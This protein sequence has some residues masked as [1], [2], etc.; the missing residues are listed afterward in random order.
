MKHPLLYGPALVFGLCGGILLACQ[1]PVF[2][3]ALERWTAGTWNIVVLSQGP[4]SPAQSLSLQML[5]QPTASASLPMKIQHIDLSVAAPAD[6]RRWASHWQA[7][8]NEAIPVVVALYPQP[9]NV[10]QPVASLMQ[11]S[12]TTAEQILSSPVR[13]ELASRLTAGHSAVWLFLDSGETQADQNALERLN[14]QLKADEQRLTLPTAADLQITP[15]QLR[16]LQIPLKLQF[17]VLRLGR[18][19][20][21]E[22]FLV[23]SLLGSE[24]DLRELSEP[25]AFPVFG[26]GRVLYALVGMGIDAK[27]ISVASDFL[28]GPCSCQVKEQNPGFDLLLTHDWPAAIGD[29]LV[30][31][32]VPEEQKSPALL[33]IPP[34][35]TTGNQSAGPSQ[36]SGK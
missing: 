15:E 4:L 28:A 30:S 19:D 26:R 32:P 2:R 17:S 11:L 31:S 13:R 10:D 7:A 14:R 12:A 22:R 24:A 21:D 3:Y 33:K 18:D 6:R 29:T 25:M 16:Q 8:G 34:G 1:A 20:P 35:R 36:K 5:Q 9:S 27:T 23:D